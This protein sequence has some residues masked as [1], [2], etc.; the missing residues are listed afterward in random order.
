[1]SELE[2]LFKRLYDEIERNETGGYSS[3][4]T[5]RKLER[6]VYNT[7]KAQEVALSDIEQDNLAYLMGADSFED[8][9]AEL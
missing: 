8:L 1:M 2:K 4:G 5:L 9:E 3:K 7:L 6:E